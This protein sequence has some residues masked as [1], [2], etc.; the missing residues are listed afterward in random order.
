[1]NRGKH[2]GLFARFLHS[3]AIHRLFRRIAL[4]ESFEGAPISRDV[5]APLAQTL[6][7]AAR[8]E[9]E[10]LL[11]TLHAHPDGLTEAE[12][13]AARRHFGPNEVEHEKP[14]PAWQ[15]LW[16][17]YKNPFNLLLTVLAAISCGHRRHQGGDRHLDHGGAVH[18]PALLAGKPLAP[19]GRQAQGHGQQHGDRPASRPRRCRRKRP[20]K[21]PYPATPDPGRSNCRSASWC[22]ATCCCCPPAT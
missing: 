19:G 14:L 13:R 12:A 9:P 10:A 17:C 5:P 8:S 4:L 3:R 1:M 18:G 20:A 2:S 21:A 15:H 22:R 11:K 7:A 16:H 6:S